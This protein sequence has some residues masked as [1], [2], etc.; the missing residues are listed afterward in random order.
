MNTQL[1]ITKNQDNNLN[2]LKSPLLITGSAHGGKSAL[3]HSTLNKEQP[4]AIIGTASTKEKEI[5]D[6]VSELK[7]AR[8]PLWESVEDYDDLP[9][10]LGELCTTFPQILIDSMNLWVADM[11]LK[12]V[13]KYSVNQLENLIFSD[14]D[15][16]IQIVKSNSEKR[17]VIVSSEIGQAPPPQTV[18]PRL[19]RKTLGIANQKLASISENV[20][21]V[22]CGIP[23]LIK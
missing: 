18:V 16:I 10:V 3:S 14:L 2:S 11:I 19:F 9:P 7:D 13:T 15:K 8:P 12:N 6:R 17:I 22:S 4:C 21:L 1:K 23:T 20:I 5:A